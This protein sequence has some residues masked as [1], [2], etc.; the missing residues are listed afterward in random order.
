MNP[1]EKDMFGNKGQMTERNGKTL[2]QRFVSVISDCDIFSMILREFTDELKD[3]SV[4]EIKGYL[5][6]DD[7]GRT[8]LGR[9][10]IY[11]PEYD[12]DFDLSTSFDVDIPGTPICV[13]F[14]AEGHGGQNA[15]YPPAVR[16]RFRLCDAISSQAGREFKGDN[17]A[18]M[19]KTYCI[20]CI[21]G[22]NDEEPGS[23]IRYKMEP[24]VKC[25]KNGMEPE[26][27]DTFNIALAYIGRYT[28]DLPEGL[29][30]LSAMFS[31]MEKSERREL[32]RNKFNIELND[33]ILES[34]KDMSLDQDRYNYGFREGK[35]EGVTEGMAKGMAEGAAKEKSSAVEIVV[36]II[37]SF[38]KE[39]GITPEEA[40][41]R[42]PVP[43][44]YREDVESR[45][46]AA[47]H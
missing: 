11:G 1:Q 26:I 41:K 10:S 20:W 21:L 28:D 27:L 16:A 8:V 39:M 40:L 14:G 33:D 47:A 17:F 29:D 32:V 30:F 7:D 18:D 46:R 22:Q 15:R 25:S 19:R 5:R 42:V 23:M 12:E 13:V 35:A 6:L 45:I 44:P 31:E 36:E 43:E 38:S 3:R 24:D 37:M 9:D 34:V 2:E 4:D